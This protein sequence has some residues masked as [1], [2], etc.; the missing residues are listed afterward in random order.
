L[1]WGAEVSAIRTIILA[2]ARKQARSFLD[3]CRAVA[4]MPVDQAV[5]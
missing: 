1:A 4:G 2:T 3:A 5:P